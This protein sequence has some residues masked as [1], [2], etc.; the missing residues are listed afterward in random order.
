[1]RS[2]VC[3]QGLTQEDMGEF[4]RLVRGLQSQNCFGAHAMKMFTSILTQME[5]GIFQ[6]PCNNLLHRL[7][8][9]ASDA[10][11]YITV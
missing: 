8:V 4:L 10:E 11:A 9:D 2:V 1:M 7:N 5:S 6:R 3:S